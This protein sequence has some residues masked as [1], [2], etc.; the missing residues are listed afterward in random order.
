M[1]KWITF[2]TLW[3]TG[4]KMAKNSIKSLK[5]G[6]GVWITMWITWIKMLV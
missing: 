2:F 5:F 4:K 3:I 6:G 1:D